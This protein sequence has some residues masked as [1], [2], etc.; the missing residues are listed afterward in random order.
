MLKGIVFYLH[1]SVSGQRPIETFTTAA[2]AQLS[3]NPLEA[4]VT[5]RGRSKP[6][7]LIAMI[8]AF[9]IQFVIAGFLRLISDLLTFTG[10]L[11]LEYDK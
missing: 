5:G 11:I 3:D 1:R 9:G 4:T 8:Q 7:L 6:S 2:H 10:P